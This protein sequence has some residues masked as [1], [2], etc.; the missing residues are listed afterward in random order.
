MSK[1]PFLD[2]E[3]PCVQD[4]YQSSFLSCFVFSVTKISVYNKI[5]WKGEAGGGRGR[6]G[7]VN[8]MGEL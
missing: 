2:P 4:L 3:P 5:E 8:G 7:E 6:P 1:K